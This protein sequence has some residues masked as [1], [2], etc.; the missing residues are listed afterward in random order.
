MAGDA[1]GRAVGSA[2]SIMTN[3]YV[4]PHMPKAMFGMGGRMIL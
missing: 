1:Q 3:A 4:I 2:T